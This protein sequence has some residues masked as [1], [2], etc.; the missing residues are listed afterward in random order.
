MGWVGI[1]EVDDFGSLGL[2]GLGAW[3]GKN[4]GVEAGL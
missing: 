4:G 3:T 2:L 1:I